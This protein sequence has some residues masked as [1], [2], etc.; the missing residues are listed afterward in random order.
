M[1]VTTVERSDKTMATTHSLCAVGELPAGE[2]KAF[3]VDG[4]GS[5]ALFNVGG[6][7][8]ATGNVCTHQIALLTEGYLDGDCVECP[9]H[10]GSFN[11]RTGAPMSFPCVTPLATYPVV[12]EDGRV[13]LRPTPQA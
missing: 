13:T 3:A 8:F 6:E 4:V 5:V 2:M 10:G 12:V 11:V 7:F 9:M 1:V